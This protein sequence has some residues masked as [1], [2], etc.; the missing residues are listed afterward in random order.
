MIYGSV[1]WCEL[2]TDKFTQVYIYKKTNFGNSID[3]AVAI[4]GYAAKTIIDALNAYHER[5]E[6]RP[7]R[8]SGA[9]STTE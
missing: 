1:Y 8:G 6:Q 9:V 4:D 2:P 7:S 3:V 5:Q